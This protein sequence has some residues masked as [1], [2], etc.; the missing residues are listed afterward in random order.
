MY[1]VVCAMPNGVNLGG[2]TVKGWARERT[3]S[4]FYVD[5][6][7]IVGG[8]GLTLNVPD[9]IWENW[10]RGNGSSDI[11][12]SGAIFGS[13]D[14]AVAVAHARTH[15]GRLMGPMAKA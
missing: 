9:D 3:Q 14:R 4:P 15:R 7:T 2:F 5:D 11:V 1:V 12:Q 13:K 10:L 6:P 8:F